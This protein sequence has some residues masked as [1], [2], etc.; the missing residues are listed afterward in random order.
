MANN[1]LW[2][3]AS[4]NNN[5]QNSKQ[6][7]KS[8]WTSGFENPFSTKTQSGAFGSKGMS[9][10][11]SSGPTSL[12]CQSTTKNQNLYSWHNSNSSSSQMSC[13][14]STSSDAWGEMIDSVIMDEIKDACNSNFSN[15]ACNSSTRRGSLIPRL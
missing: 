5:N 9:W 13:A 10:A 12:P 8:I 11:S 7:Q 3:N 4:W 15:F 6:S 1:N 14:S 2:S